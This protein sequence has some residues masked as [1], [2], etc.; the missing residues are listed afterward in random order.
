MTIQKAQL[1]DVEA[2]IDIAMQAWPSTYGKIISQAQINYMLQAF[3]NKEVIIQQIES[4]D[5]LFL[6]AKKNEVTLGYI[7]LLLAYPVIGF[8]KI[9][10]LYLLPHL[11]GQNIGGQLMQ[12]AERFSLEMGVHTIIL[13]VNRNNS[14]Q[15]FYKKQ[16][17]AIT[18]SLDI[19]L[20]KFWLN[21]FIMQKRI[22]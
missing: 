4:K 11:Q 2:I 3:Y 8:N 20:N 22:G 10:K 6:V 1:K 21:D 13:N 7:H 9:S 17:Y 5:H 14:A 19:P 12:V 18:Q 15:E 16:G